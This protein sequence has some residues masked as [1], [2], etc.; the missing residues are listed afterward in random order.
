MANI[1]TITIDTTA[2]DICPTIF[3]GSY[4]GTE[5][6]RRIS[7]ITGYSDLSQW[8]VLETL[9][10]ETG[11]DQIALIHY[12]PTGI[13]ECGAARGDVYDLETGA[14]IAKSFGHTPIAVL[15][16]IVIQDGLIDIQ[17]EDNQI[18]TFDPAACKIK[19]GVE[20]VVF[21]VIRHAGKMHFFTH[22]RLTPSRSRW[23]ASPFF[24]EMYR[25]AGGPTEEQLFDLTTPYSSTC[26]VFAV[27][28]PA[29]LVATRQIV[30]AP[31]IVHLASFEMDLKRPAEEVSVGIPT[32]ITSTEITGSV[33]TSFI[34]SPLDL[35]IDEANIYLNYGYYD[36][37][38][39]SDIRQQ[40][41]EMVIIYSMDPE[42]NIQ[43]I[44]K[45]HSSSYEWRCQTRSNNPNIVNRFYTMLNW[46]HDEP[47]TETDWVLLRKRL[48]FFPNY[49]EAELKAVYDQHG[50]ILALPDA[51]TTI[52]MF[53]SREARIHLLWMNYVL[54][55]PPCSQGEGLKI[56]AAFKED[57]NAVITWFCQLEQIRDIDTKDITVLFP[58][59]ADRKMG[60]QGRKKY[61]AIFRRVQGLI[62]SARRLARERV[63]AKLNYNQRGGY[64][65]LT[66]IIK[67]TLSN[68][69]RKEHGESLY[70]LVRI[71]KDVQGKL[72]RSQRSEA[73]SSIEAVETVASSE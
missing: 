67:M 47:K 14:L 30:T 12:E 54:S 26:Y 60:E 27:V 17:D 66:Q 58:D 71:M 53:K 52:D 8:S 37:Y 28:H 29:L 24:L 62:S 11:E 33:T 19:R 73:A 44:V 40:T 32:F 38:P 39:Q 72:P 1:S 36:E 23:G 45:V 59:F 25:E 57:R 4:K 21:R 48:L 46:V 2:A 42:G 34:H 5:T 6:Q 10:T 9:K 55:L 63:D 43:D 31:Y 16:Q 13:R 64:L 18:H 68:L 51:P 70:N 61:L 3:D 69:I 20:C 50:A 56:L 35:T 15:D 22:R 41:G 65:K 49:P 7:E